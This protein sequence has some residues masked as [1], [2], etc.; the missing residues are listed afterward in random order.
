MR[1]APLD[2]LKP[3]QTG[4]PPQSQRRH[5]L[6]MAWEEINN[7]G[8]IYALVQIV[9]AGSI[10]EC[11]DAIRRDG[12]VSPPLMDVAEHVDLRP[13]ASLDLLQEAW[14]SCAIVVKSLVTTAQGRPMGHQHVNPSRDLAP[15]VHDL[16]PWPLVESPVPE[17]RL[18]GRT[19]D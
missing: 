9:D 7:N 4:L 11:G 10:D 19:M 12:V 2:A 1:C 17:K 16:C 6:A 15:T 3:T 8:W 14:A 13:D 18:P 5:L